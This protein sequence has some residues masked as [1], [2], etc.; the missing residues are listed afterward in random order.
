MDWNKLL[1]DAVQYLFI[2]YGD[3]IIAFVFTAI[4]GFLINLAA[5]TGNKYVKFI[6]EQIKEVVVVAQETTVADFKKASAKGVITKEDG[7]IIKNNVLERSK[8]K[9]GVMGKLFLKL[10]VG[11]V[12]KWVSEQIELQLAKVKGRL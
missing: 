9:I 3:A 2:H 11:D 5:T 4:T 10:F 7:I 8:E 6:A 12:E 1:T